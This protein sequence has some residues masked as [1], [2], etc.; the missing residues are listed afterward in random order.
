[1]PVI[2]IPLE[3]LRERIRSPRPLSQD[4]LLILLAQLGCD[5]EGVASL[6]RCKC[7][8]CGFVMELVGK[9]DVPPRCDRCDRDLRSEPSAT[10]EMAP[11]EVVRMEL[12]AVRPDIFDP[13][14]LARALRGILE[15]ETGLPQYELG[16]V[17]A[18]LRIDDSVRREESLRPH[19]ACAVIEGLRFDDDR[20][21]ILMKLQ[22]NL[23]WALGRD[24]KHA[25]IGVYDLDALGA[26]GGDG[27]LDLEYTTVEPEFSFT[28]LGFDVPQSCREILGTHPKGRAY[29]HLLAGFDRYPLLRRASGAVLSMPPV[30]NS[31]ETKVHLGTTRLFIDVTG[32]GRRITQRT[33]NILVTS[34]LEMDGAAR[35][36]AVELTNAT[37][38]EG[39]TGG[40]SLTTPDLLPQR[41]RI[42]TARTA[43]LLGIPLDDA[44][45]RRLLERM[46]H[47]VSGGGVLEIDVAAYRNDIFHERD[48][49]EDAA[50]AFG[51]DRIPRTLVPTLTVGR[52]HPLEERSAAVR[53]VLSGLGFLENMTLPL[54]SHAAADGL[55]GLDPHTAT[56]L[57]ENPISLEQTQL[58]TS[59]LPGLLESFGR[60]RHHPLPQQLFEVGDVTFADAGAETGA[61]EVRHLALGAIAPKV[62]FAEIRGWVEAIARELGWPFR[63]AVAETSFLIPGRSA[64]ILDPKG[65][66][67]GLFGEVHPEVLERVGLQNPVVVVEMVVGMDAGEYR[68]V[69]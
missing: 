69:S 11:L 51:Y 14:G 1:M 36:F 2:G 57:L 59:L 21:K 28:P 40:E 64:W 8:G 37:T 55:L 23:H 53:E 47:G 56:T 68:S 20:I 34:L 29:A 63:A 38:E 33:L 24:R 3:A 31:D 32:S 10:I 62:G 66:R 44:T 26:A 41:A 25:S 45:L 54:V 30:I 22:E 4:E 43:R 13:A 52:E 17:C 39:H 49:M 50:I 27:V 6:R 12:L 67:A 48:L 5:V 61:R 35:L 16:P 46:R 58:R 15:I 19:I 7:R 60:N 18:R 42:D 65:R 9:E